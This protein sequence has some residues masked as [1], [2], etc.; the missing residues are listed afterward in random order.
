MLKTYLLE[1][2][3]IQPLQGNTKLALQFHVS[4][5]SLLKEFSCIPSIRSLDQLKS[6]ECP[7]ALIGSSVEEYPQSVKKLRANF[8]TEGVKK[9]NLKSSWKGILSSL[10]DCLTYI[11]RSMESL[12][13]FPFFFF[14]TGINSNLIRP[15]FKSGDELH[16][17]WLWQKEKE[18]QTVLSSFIFASEVSIS[19]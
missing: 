9:I 4:N 7:T 12:G 14:H 5:T 19:H 3:Q 18:F 16:S 6:T 1:G 10:L 15:S 13:N 11:N 2:P 8:S 17:F